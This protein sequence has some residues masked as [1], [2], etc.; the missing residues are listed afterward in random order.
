MEV[1]LFERGLA[2][3]LSLLGNKLVNIIQEATWKCIPF[4]I[5]ELEE[6]RLQARCSIGDFQ[7]V[8]LGSFG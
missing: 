8:L 4:T 1:F 5:S 7:V 2:R 3:V 6:L